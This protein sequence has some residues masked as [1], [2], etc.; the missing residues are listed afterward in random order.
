MSADWVM[1]II[2]GVYVIATIV[3]CW[4]NF[5]SANASKE[6]LNEM[7]Q[8]YADTNR[9]ILEYEFHYSR[10]TWYSVR[11]I[12]HGNRTAQHVKINLDQSFIN[13]LPE[14]S[15]KKEAERLKGKEC[16]IGV[17]QYYELFVGSNKLRDNP[18]MVPL[19]GTIEYEA[20]GQKYK[21]DIFV[22]LEHYMT[23]FT[24]TTDEDDLLKTLK[25]ISTQLK[26]INQV[27]ELREERKDQNTD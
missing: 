17:G 5:K 21:N 1:V 18:N 16:I 19:T 15:F 25:E 22:D 8:Q 20:Q 14:E 26:S 9:P 10:R 2:T 27:L 12:N 24:V 3:I 7:R 11:F 6:Q 4:A 23:F 13:S